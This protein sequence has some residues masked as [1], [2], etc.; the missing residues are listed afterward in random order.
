MIDINSVIIIILFYAVNM[1]YIR[2]FSV[3]EKL[4]TK[5]ENIVYYGKDIGEQIIIYF[6]LDTL[7]ITISFD[8]R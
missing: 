5:L 3:S 1:L 2:T 4:I 8:I 6:K 7:V